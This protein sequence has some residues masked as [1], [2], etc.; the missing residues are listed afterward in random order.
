MK[1]ETASSAV[2]GTNMNDEKVTKKK[3]HCFCGACQFELIGSH[4]WVG[5]CHCESCRRATASPMTTWIGHENGR[6][7]ITGIQ[8]ISYESSKGNIRAFCPKCGSPIFY[9]SDRYPNEVHFYASLLDDPEA[10]TP[11]SH[12]HFEE[13][14]SWMHIS[15]N[16]KK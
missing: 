1:N 2:K 6:W 9:K 7:K 11:T 5:H 3:G 16:L 14:L 10:V 8:P 4:N 12:S 13:K 15:D